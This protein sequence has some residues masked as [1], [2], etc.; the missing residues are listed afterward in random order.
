[1][2]DKTDPTPDP[3]LRTYLVR[4]RFEGFRPQ[5]LLE[6]DTVPATPEEAA[7]Y[8]NNGVLLESPTES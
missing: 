7:P 5:P 1:M 8:L 2:A 6:G 4:W 3:A